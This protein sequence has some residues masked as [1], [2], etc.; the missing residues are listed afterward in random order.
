MINYVEKV[1]EIWLLNLNIIEDIV[2]CNQDQ[3]IL[4][5]INILV[6]IFWA[7][8]MDDYY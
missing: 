1:E 8:L 5:N 6:E 3:E 4:E 2:E 7:M